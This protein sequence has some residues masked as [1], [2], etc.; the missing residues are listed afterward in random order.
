MKKC[1]Y[2]GRKSD[3][4]VKAS[5]RGKIVDICER[6]ASSFYKCEKCGIYFQW[7]DRHMIDEHIFCKK[8]SSSIA[9]HECNICHKVNVV[10]GDVCMSCAKEFYINGYS[11]KPEPNF[12]VYDKNDK[13]DMFMGIELEINF[14]DNLAFKNFLQAYHE[15]DFVYLKHDGSLGHCGVEIVSH[16]ATVKCHLHKYWKDIFEMFKHTDTLGCGLHFHLSKKAFDGNE[17]QFLDYFINNFPHLICQI[18]SRALKDYCK[19][20]K[21]RSWNHW[22]YGR[23]SEHTDACN[24]SNRNTIELRFCKSTNNY[25]SFIK[26]IKNIWTILMFVKL[27]NQQNKVDEFMKAVNHD[28]VEKYFNYFKGELLSRI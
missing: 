1:P 21:L 2:C 6:C 20:V 22:G 4:F 5:I 23:H 7:F 28:M 9:F 8:C 10:D 17:V 16:P 25:H 13:D 24:L 14:N 11:F 18:G 12:T 3:K 15:D 19:I 26:K 27:V